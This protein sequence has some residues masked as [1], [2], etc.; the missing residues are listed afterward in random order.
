MPPTANTMEMNV[1]EV[2]KISQRLQETAETLTRISDALKMAIE[3]LNKTAFVGVFG[4]HILSA[5]M[6]V[7][8][9]KIAQMA[10]NSLK[11]KEY[12]DKEINDWIRAQQVGG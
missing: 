2:K 7:M 9:P 1:D 3:L 6:Q 10:K 5:F 12:V 8:Q 4:G 11:T